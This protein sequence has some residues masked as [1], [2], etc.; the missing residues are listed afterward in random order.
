[1]PSAPYALLPTN[2]AP[3]EAAREMEDAFDDEDDD[4]AVDL[5][6]ESTPLNPQRL[7]T[8]VQHPQQPSP[9]SAISIPGSYDFERD[10]DYA[11][12]PPGSPPGLSASAQP[13]NYGNS[14]GLIPSPSS[15]ITAP[16]GTR[17]S[18]SFFRKAVG[19][20]LPSH[21]QRVAT[22][23][24]T[25]RIIGGGVEN[26][27]V[28]ANVMAKPVRGARTIRTEDGN[29]YL[30][31]EET[32]KEAPPTYAEA[33]TDSVPTYW[34]TTVVTPSGLD[35]SGDMI[36]NDLPTGSVL[37]FAF[38][39]FT[40]FF[41]QYLGFVI[42]YFL[43]TSHAAKYGSRAGLGLT[44]IQ[45]GAYWRVAT[46]T[47]GNTGGQEMVWLNE[48]SQTWESF[49]YS[50]SVHG[51][52]NIT[53]PV[54]SLIDNIFNNTNSTLNPPGY[55]HFNEFKWNSKDWVALLFMTFGWL[56]LF[57]S[58]VGF[59]RVK[60]W[61]LSIRASSQPPSSLTT[62]DVRDIR[63]RRNLELVFGVGE[64]EEEPTD[65]EERLTEHLRAA[66]LI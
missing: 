42:T 17:G 50:H 62:Q 35:D 14:N 28:F 9:Q 38:N 22:E 27:G 30:A 2:P 31:P 66:G 61:E 54:S 5:G 29:I 34:D 46:G 41:F 43:S 51:A 39:L 12:P 11:L 3:H 53:Y 58:I 16:T 65:G 49:T 10:Y 36:V 13:N 45:Y 25:S 55:G 1:M 20:L 37:V 19:V 60:R 6:H 8:A 7:A 4:E 15:I 21:Y 47:E 57:S 26:D 52:M 40:S 56:L 24:P 23:A 48:T 44:M 18:P 33:Q 64:E 32:Q 59:W 63:V